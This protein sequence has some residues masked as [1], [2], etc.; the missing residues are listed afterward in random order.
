MTAPLR[1]QFS[2]SALRARVLDDALAVLDAEVASKTGLGGIAIKATF[3]I[4]KGVGAGFVRTVLDKLFDDFISCF[5]EP[6]QRAIQAGKSP[7]AL[8]AEEKAT[9]ATRL[10]SITDERVRRSGNGAI[11]KAY[12]KLRPA[13]QRH[14]EEAAPR[15]AGLLDRHAQRS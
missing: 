5:E 10:L 14:V 1:E 8:V 13:A 9:I 7:G 4:V 3:G 11:S 2:D 12:E 15:L 6:Y